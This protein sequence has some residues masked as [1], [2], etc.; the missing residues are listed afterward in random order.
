MKT[1]KKQDLLT[2]RKVTHLP[3]V[4]RINF[5]TLGMTTN[6]RAPE[7][8]EASSIFNCA[9]VRQSAVEGRPSFK[10]DIASRP[11]SPSTDRFIAKGFTS[12]S[13][14]ERSIKGSSVAPEVCQSANI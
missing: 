5:R 13:E 12:L 14:G 3:P 4:A 2:N 7:G 1:T 9:A 6:S 10:Y 8:F 11:V